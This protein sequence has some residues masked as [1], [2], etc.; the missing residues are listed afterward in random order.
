MTEGPAA[1]HLIARS[2]AGTGAHQREGIDRPYERRIHGPRVDR[3]G[4]AGQCRMRHKRTPIGHE[5]TGTQPPIEVPEE[6]QQGLR[7]VRG[8]APKNA[9]AGPM[10]YPVDQ[11]GEGVA[12]DRIGGTLGARAPLPVHVAEEGKGDVQIVGVGLPP[13]VFGQRREDSQQP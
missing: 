1:Q 6:P 2:L 10:T 4:L 11:Q 8:P 9:G 7:A 3:P 5:P 12:T 13:V